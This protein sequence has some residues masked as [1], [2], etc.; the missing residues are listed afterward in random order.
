M[1]LRALHAFRVIAE[2]GSITSAAARLGTVQSALSARIARLE[3]M[4]GAVLFE[5]L[6]RGIRLTPAGSRLLPYAEK[7]ELLVAEAAAA[8]HD[9]S[10]E[11]SGPFQL[12]A[13]EIVAATILP[14]RLARFLAAHPNIDLRLSTDVSSDLTE[15]VNCGAIDAA[16]IADGY[17]P[18]SLVIK[19]LDCLPLALFRP[20]DRAAEGVD[21][22]FAFS[23]GC[24]CRA[25]LE[26]LIHQRRWSHRIIELASV[27]AILGCVEAGLG[28]ALLP[29]TLHERRRV[30]SEPAGQLDLSLIYAPGAHA[31]AEALAVNLMK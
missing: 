5:R 10:P 20:A 16:I 11:L 18:S 19:Q 29:A 23:S 25:R 9:D 14:D 2:T 8:I 17:R 7:L 28:V 15:A 30:A 21:Q 12:G 4:I 31:A 6:P 24:V 13:I 3:F 22:A 26:A 1:D 27:D